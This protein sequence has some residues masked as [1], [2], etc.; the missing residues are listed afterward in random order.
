MMNNP[1]C[2]AKDKYKIINWSSY[3]ESLKTRGSI[4]FWFSEETMQEWL[5]SGDQQQGGE[6]IYSNTAIEVCLTIR[7][8]YHLALRQ[9]EGFMGSLVNMMQIN[10]PIPSYSQ[11][12]RRAK[13]LKIN[14]EKL[15]TKE[16]LHIV[17]DS[18]GLKVYGE[19]EWKVRQHGWSKHRTWRKLHLGVEPSSNFIVAEM[20]TN[21]GVDDAEPVEKL[22]AEIK[23]PIKSFGGDGAY[24][25]IKVRKILNQH[26]IQQKIPPQHNA[27]LNKTG[28][29]DWLERNVAIKVIEVIGRVAWKKKIGYHQRSKAEVA[30]FRYKTI[31]GEKL[32]SRKFENEIVE[33]RLSCLIL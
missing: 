23:Q 30:M 26:G 28:E 16:P 14:L 17:V 9:T 33:A 10:L 18:T 24:D 13:T 15:A 31:I 21:N 7:K 1:S 11:L 5:Y 32:Q 3:N 2:K 25:K 29:E 20:L 12:C 4:T 22:L 19:G 8:V 6:I 27:V